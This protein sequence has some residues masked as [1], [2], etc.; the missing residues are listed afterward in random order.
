MTPGDVERLPFVVRRFEELK[1]LRMVAIGVVWALVFGAGRA[2][3]VA[4]LLGDWGLTI[5]ILVST[6]AIFCGLYTVDRY[7][8]TRFG[9]VQGTHPS[10]AWLRT[11]VAVAL[12]LAGM[13]A[14][15]GNLPYL[16][17]VGAAFF[18]LAI[19]DWPFRRHCL[20]GAAAS[21]FAAGAALASGAPGSDEQFMAGFAIV[22]VGLIGVGL[23]D[24][25]LLSRT[26]PGLH[27]AETALEGEAQ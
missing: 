1:G 14:G 5:M 27:R 20:L 6:V 26:L 10:S 13:R 11:T 21:G 7:Y 16:I 9:R 2:Q 4:R 18:W 23:L 8:L 22:G 15:I 12:M 3:D 25:R 24:H 19:R 17:G